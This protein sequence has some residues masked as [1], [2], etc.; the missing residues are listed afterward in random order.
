[1]VRSVLVPLDGSP[2]S[3]QALPLAL[4]IAR[5]AQAALEV[6]YVHQP[7]Q[8]YRIPSAVAPQLDEQAQQDA[9]AYLASVVHRLGAQ[10][11]VAATPTLLLGTAADAL[12][13]HALARG[14][15]LVVMTTHGRSPL[16]RF[17]LGSVADILMRRLP[18]PLLLVR[19]QE[20]APAAEPVLQRILIPL[21]G[22]ALAEQVLE[23]ALAVGALMQAE[24][25]L[26]GVVEP[27]L[28]LDDDTP[29]PRLLGFGPALQA[30]VRETRERQR[31][32]ATHY[33]EATAERLRSRSLRV[34]VR[35]VTA[36]N[37]AAAILDEAQA[38]ASDLIALATQGRGGLTRLALGSVA[39]KVVRG[40]TMPV[41]VCRP[42]Q[43]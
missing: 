15:D 8:Y 39:D 18:M 42:R 5:R 28:E 36:L 19:P 4:S 16:S 38:R 24:F 2:F 11:P 23:P 6:A 27:M 22:S 20:P 26:L 12:H 33:L 35:V 25:T 31:T 17:W 29:S 3:E 14:I 40:A 10:A 43:P 7:L 34:Q 9:R 30:A 13:D 37:P 32:E 41:L 1:M 21:D